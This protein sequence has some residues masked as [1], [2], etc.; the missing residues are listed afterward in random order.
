MTKEARAEKLYENLWE[1]V[2]ILRSKMDPNDYKNY[3]LGLVFYKYLSDK[4]LYC[5]AELLEKEPKNLKEA[6]NIYEEACSDPKLSSNLIEGIKEEISFVIEPDL[7]FT[8][9][10]EKAYGKKFELK[11]LKNAF[12][13]IEQ[14]NDLFVSLFQDVDLNS[15]KLGPTIE[16]QTETLTEVMKKIYECDLLV[17]SDVV[18]DAY[19]SL[20]GKFASISGKT[21]GEFYTPQPVSELMARIVMQ[22]KQ[23]KMGVSV[24]DPT[25][26]SGSLL[27]TV[28]KYSEE[29]NTIS[30]FGQEINNSTF[31]LA[32]MNMILHGVDI[33][34]QTLRNGDTLGSDWPVEKPVYFD[35][36][37]MNPTYSVKWSADKELL[38]DPRFSS[39]GV[40]APKSK[41]D[42][43][44]LLHG[45]HHLKSDGTMAI[46]LPHGVLF[47]G[48]AESV[49]REKLLKQGVIESVIG[50]PA[51]IF[52]NTMIP[53]TIIVLRKKTEN[54]DVFFI[55]ASELF[56][57]GKSQNKLLKE[58]ILK[59]LKVYTT[60]KNEPH[61]SHLATFNEVEEYDF[62]L[63]IPLYVSTVKEEEPIDLKELGKEM[64][65]IDQEIV[66]SNQ[67]LLEMLK[68]LEGKNEE[69]EEILQQFIQ[70]V[71][72]RT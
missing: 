41:A 37:I 68:Q 60:K 66:K 34:N 9:L 4:L 48:G 17:E 63:N 26:G 53:T 2:E 72:W 11:K 58:H 44:F 29:K 24:Y 25:M 45:F 18:G 1:S 10:I 30:Y 56:E 27:L 57:K 8:S 14:S 43:A 46:V 16:K 64:N 71:N 42:F 39:Y 52:F 22:G 61:F 36:V 15:K 32:R 19:E 5:S 70:T 20:I 51:N 7:T 12:E 13:K 55:D 38:E 31:N 50:L 54:R 67:N 21:A 6:Q 47:R 65:S 28:K 62:N 59:I 40:L 49:I 23:N 33:S 69:E 3:L 35:T